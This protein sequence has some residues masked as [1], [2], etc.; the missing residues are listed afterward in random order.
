MA[1]IHIC[2]VC[3]KEFDSEQGYLDH[4]CE[5]TGFTPTEIEHQGEEFKAI[6]EA[7]IARGEAKKG[8]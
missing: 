4:K 3:G 5:V 1:Q 6:S 7:A 8:E 2:S